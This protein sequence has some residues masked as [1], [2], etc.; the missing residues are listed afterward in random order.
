MV[1]Y[2]HRMLAV[3]LTDALKRAWTLNRH[4]FVARMFFSPGFVYAFSVQQAKLTQGDIE[5]WSC[6]APTEQAGILSTTHRWRAGFE[7]LRTPGDMS[8]SLDPAGVQ[9]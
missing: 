7:Q 9:V 2:E 8:G 5:R 1:S 6:C 3:N 4:L